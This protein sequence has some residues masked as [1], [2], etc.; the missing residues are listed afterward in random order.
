ML[1]VLL[2]TV[3]KHS[4]ASGE[5]VCKTLTFSNGSSRVFMDL[6]NKHTDT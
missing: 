3:T 5:D 2:G 4:L 1:S 6:K